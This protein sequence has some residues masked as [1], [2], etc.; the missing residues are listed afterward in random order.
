M[1]S[2]DIKFTPELI[3]DL[4]VRKKILRKKGILADIGDTH[5]FQVALKQNVEYVARMKITAAYGGTFIIA[6][7]GVTT[8]S[9][10]SELFGSPITNHMIETKY[11][12][13]GTTTGLLQI[14]YSTSILHQEFPTYTMYFNKT[15]FAGLVVDNSIW[16]R[17][18]SNFSGHFYFHDY[19]F[20]INI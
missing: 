19:W 5:W 20:D 14:T 13:D 1:N 18:I 7:F 2:G 11:T 17:S 4:I 3:N 16:D 9:F 15:G 8:N 6:L 12:A 10:Y